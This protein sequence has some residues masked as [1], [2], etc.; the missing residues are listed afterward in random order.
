LDT[1]E[2][3]SKITASVIGC[4]KT[5]LLTACLLAETGFKTLIVDSDHILASL[6]K[7]GKSASSSHELAKLIKKH[8]KSGGLTLT[9]NVREAASKSAVVIIA[10]S[11][12][13]DEK[14]KPDYTHLERTSKEIGAGLQSGSLVLVEGI[15]GPGVTETLVKELLQKTSG[16]KAG[17]DFSL[18]V[19]PIST[20]YEAFRNT[21]SSTRI[22]G[23]LD[24]RSLTATCLFLK[25]LLKSQITTVKNIRTAEAI[26][27]FESVHEDVNHALS[28]ELARF[29]EKAGVDFIECQKAMSAHL[30]FSLPASNVAKRYFSPEPYL[31]FEEAE[32]SGSL[33]SLIM[34]A[35]KINEEML[36]QTVHMTKEALKSC[37]KMFRRARITVLGVSEHLDPA[38]L[39]NYFSRNL[40]SSLIRNGARVRVYDP[41]FSVKELT[42]LGFQAEATLGKAIEGADCL[43]IAV[44]HER[45]KRLNL[46][47]IRFLMKQPAALVDVGNVVDPERAM[48]EGFVYR[49]LGRG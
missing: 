10:N 27:I 30:P 16:L 48:K 43:L 2:K 4:G 22:I 41:L 17:I 31:F 37:S 38:A 1:R 28:L 13:V 36:K 25:S 21:A 15:V 47:R 24:E 49:G 35:R 11:P 6:I 5:G 18:A 9:N 40:V 29:C 14:K 8:T 3:R 20:T 42:E 34:Q 39:D 7:K 32:N 45:F 46:K 19:C 33:L 26:G 23:A 12:L 44:G